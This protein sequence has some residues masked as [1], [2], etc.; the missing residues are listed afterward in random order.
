MSTIS[1]G[2]RLTLGTV[3][4]IL[5]S[6]GA[7]IRGCQYFISRNPETRNYAAANYWQGVHGTMN[8]QR[9]I[10]EMIPLAGN[11]ATLL[12][13]RCIGLRGNYTH[14]QLSSGVDP[15]FASAPAQ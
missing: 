13:D 14:E 1:G 10:I 6:I 8:A 4:N 5:G 15:L 2:I 12:Y 7:A 9:G 11:L 3:Q